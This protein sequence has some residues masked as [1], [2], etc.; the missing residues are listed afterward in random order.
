V[1]LVVLSGALYVFV[2][3]VPGV[4][5]T[6]SQIG[7]ALAGKLTEDQLAK[8]VDGILAIEKQARGWCPNCN[9]AVMVTIPDAKG[10][11]GALVDLANQ[12]WG[13]PSEDKVESEGIA[14]TR[15]VNL[16]SEDA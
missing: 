3:G 5:D 15:I 11:S 8:L 10:V 2:R 1:G 13:R 12:A 9:K 4:S 7:D 14:F 16:R 6:R